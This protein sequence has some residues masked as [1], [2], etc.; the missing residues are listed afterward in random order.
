M[1]FRDYIKQCKAKIRQ[2]RPDAS[3]TIIEWNA[4]FIFTPSNP[5][6]KGILLVHG[7][8]DSPFM[9]RD[10]GQIFQ[11]QGYLVY[12]LLLPGHGTRPADLLS[13]SYPEWIDAVAFGMRALQ[14]ETPRVSIAGFSTGATL[15]LHY[16][17]SAPKD[18]EKV[19][20]FSPACK[21]KSP[22]AILTGLFGLL[23][24]WI[25]RLAFL[26]RL[27]EDDCVKYQTVAFKAAW[28]VYRLTQKIKHLKLSLPLFL[29]ISEQDETVSFEAALSFFKKQ[30][31]PKNQMLV[32]SN[33][34]YPAEKN[35]LAIDSNLPEKNIL[36]LSH[37]GMIISPE[38]PH[39]GEHGDYT[40][41]NQEKYQADYYGNVVTVKTLKDGKQV[42]R[43]FYNP[44]FYQL[45][46]LIN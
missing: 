41:K 24:K 4:P 44:G 27:P 15:A 45:A 3:E 40:L 36:G 28:Q 19:Y 46:T 6:H 42:S 20:C 34:A 38:N 37:H 9:M 30:T 31:N 32:F 14:Q 22:W 23:G 10:L 8:L 26:E 17:A 39:Y 35:I 29:A 33:R 1:D 7:L 2:A 13:V 21:I 5:N 16:A 18:L 43:L 12:A 11:E 25:P